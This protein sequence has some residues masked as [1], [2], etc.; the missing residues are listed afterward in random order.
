MADLI[1]AGAQQGQDSTSYTN[2][3]AR[4]G[5]TS[6]Q[7]VRWYVG[8]AAAGVR[9][10]DLVR[11]DA[12]GRSFVVVA[13]GDDLYALDDRCSHQDESLSE[14]G[15]VDGDELECCAHGARFDLASGAATG[16]PAT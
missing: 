8:P 11:V 10:G 16:L 2:A 6:N 15:A 4:D 13:I 7:T 3:P 1:L 14:V 9:D 12:G 5:E